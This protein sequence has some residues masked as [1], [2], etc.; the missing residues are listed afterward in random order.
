ML[1]GKFWC[2]EAVCGM[3]GRHWKVGVITKLWTRKHREIWKSWWQ[4]NTDLNPD[5]RCRNLQ[6][7]LCILLTTWVLVPVM[8]LTLFTH[9]THHSPLLILNVQFYSFFSLYLRHMSEFSFCFP[10]HDL[11]SSRLLQTAGF[12]LNTQSWI[13]FHYMY[14]SYLFCSP[15]DRYLSCSNSAFMKA[16]AIA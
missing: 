2:P 7:N 4:T 14:I 10:T 1:F 5:F 11:C 13:V 9:L 3:I 15:I 8:Q 6:T 12:H 16:G